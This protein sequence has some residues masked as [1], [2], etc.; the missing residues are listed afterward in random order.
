[1]TLP[2]AEG[3]QRDVKNGYKLGVCIGRIVSVNTDACTAIIHYYWGK[4]W[5]GVWREWSGKDKT[6]YTE[7]VSPQS[8]LTLNN[9][10]DAPIARLSWKPYGRGAQKLDAASLNI[11][12]SIAVCLSDSNR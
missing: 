5:K 12:T 7:E 6:P 2:D 11:V 1:M 8:L 4:S 9:S 10:D 3:R